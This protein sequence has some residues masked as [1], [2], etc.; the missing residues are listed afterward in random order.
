VFRSEVG[1]YKALKTDIGPSAQARGVFKSG[2]SSPIG[3]HFQEPRNAGSR[4]QVP[5]FNSLPK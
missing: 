5:F 1:S 3:E 2:V 4:S